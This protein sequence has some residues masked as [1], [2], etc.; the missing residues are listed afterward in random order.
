MTV[1][2][3]GQSRGSLSSLGRDMVILPEGGF[4]FISHLSPLLLVQGTVG[5][6]GV[7]E[8]THQFWLLLCE[9]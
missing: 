7:Y 9:C 5:R 3:L 1:M 6:G 2:C 8:E 4:F